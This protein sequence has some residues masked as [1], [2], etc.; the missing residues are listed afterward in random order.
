MKKLVRC[1]ARGSNDLIPHVRL[2]V[3]HNGLLLAFLGYFWNITVD[4]FLD[5]VKCCHK[6]TRK[7]KPL[8]DDITISCAASLASNQSGVND[9]NII[10][11][12]LSELCS[13][14][15]SD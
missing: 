15:V 14:A 9:A 5:I 13:V 12:V 7:E 10:Q 4:V 8:P 1:I 11:L 6:S 2:D 3:Y